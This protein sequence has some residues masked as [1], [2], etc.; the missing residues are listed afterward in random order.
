MNSNLIDQ[1]SREFG[2]QLTFVEYTKS[3]VCKADIDRMFDET[4]LDARVAY[5]M[6]RAP[7]N[8][9]AWHFFENIHNYHNLMLVYN[10]TLLTT[11]DQHVSIKKIKHAF[12]DEYERTCYLCLE[13][14]EDGMSCVTCSQCNYIACA[15]CHL[16]YRSKISNQYFQDF[17]D[18]QEFKC[19]GC[20]GIFE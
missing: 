14:I 13:H 10:R 4:Q 15:A 16:E 20:R 8:F 12:F 7:R 9:Y 17:Q 18:F 3:I 5:I 1:L 19:P 2:G 6:W 11:D